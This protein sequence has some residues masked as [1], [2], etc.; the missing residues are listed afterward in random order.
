MLQIVCTHFKVT[1]EFLFTGLHVFFNLCGKF[2]LFRLILKKVDQFYT[3]DCVFRLIFS[4]I[5]SIWL[6]KNHLF[7]NST[8]CIYIQLV[9][10]INLPKVSSLCV[11]SFFVVVY[12]RFKMTHY[13]LFGKEFY[14][15]IHVSWFPRFWNLTYFKP[16]FLFYTT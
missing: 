7:Q 14:E 1:Q 9:Y 8:S 13:L 16:M 15:P 10:L 2:S 11:C 3:L 5:S 4:M 6:F 12:I